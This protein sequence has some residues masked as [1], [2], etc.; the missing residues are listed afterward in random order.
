M[1]IDTKAFFTARVFISADAAIAHS[2][3]STKTSLCSYSE[4]NKIWLD[5]LSTEADSLPNGRTIFVRQHLD[6]VWAVE[7]L[8]PAH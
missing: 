1:V 6:E 4:C 8:P 3:E 5:D 2:L 7:L